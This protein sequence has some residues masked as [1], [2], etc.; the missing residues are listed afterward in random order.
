VRAISTGQGARR[1]MPRE[2]RQRL[3]HRHV[4]VLGHRQ[5]LGLQPRV[6]RQ[7]GAVPGQEQR[8]LAHPRLHLLRGA[9]V[10]LGRRQ[11]GR[12]GGH[13]HQL[14]PQ[15][16]LPHHDHQRAARGQQRPRLAHRQV[17]GRGAVVA[18]EDHRAVS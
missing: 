11:A 4:D 5:P 18:D 13:L 10:E 6:A 1:A 7:T 12:G 16:R 8:A 9:H 17:G 2:A 14:Q 3:V 15:A